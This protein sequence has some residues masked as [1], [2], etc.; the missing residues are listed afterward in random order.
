MNFK[1]REEIL[2]KNLSDGEAFLIFNKEDIYYLSGFYG[3]FGILL[4]AKYKSILFVDGRYYEK[5]KKATDLDE[6]FL[7]NDLFADMKAI[8][9]SLM[10]KKVFFDSDTITFSIY[11]KLFKELP[12]ISF[13]E[14]NEKIIKKMR[15]IKDPEEIDILKKAVKKSRSA[16]REFL[17]K[18]ALIGLKE[19]EC[20]NNLEYCLKKYGDGIS[21]DTL[22]LSGKNSSLPHGN[23]SR[24]KIKNGEA[25]IID[26]GIKYQSYCT[27]HTRTLIFSNSMMERY[28]KI[29]KEAF[30]SGLSKIS[31]GKEIKEVD[32]AVR[33]V[34]ES[35]GVLKN[36]LHSSGHGIGLSVHES[37][38]ITYKNDGKFVAGMVVTLE[39]GLYF[40]G[41]GGVRYEEM[42]LVTKNGC[43]IL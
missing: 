12:S 18:F 42:I 34:F 30:E 14:D 7:V 40:E 10:I 3:S 21:F 19:I 5:A 20:V 2:K 28:L 8:I 39:P 15:E 4:I 29:A 22:I 32:I 26:Y 31:H 17:S 43:E 36:F 11:K 37:P 38:T 23:P 6:I 13:I 24:K 9:N 25:V 33:K 41:I 35:Y 1:K 27:D 16:Y